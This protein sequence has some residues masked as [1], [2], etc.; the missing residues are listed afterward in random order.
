M[1]Y[2]QKGRPLA[3]LSVCIGRMILPFF[4]LRL[5]IEGLIRKNNAILTAYPKWLRCSRLDGNFQLAIRR[6]LR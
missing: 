3:A 4:Y 1:L 6:L 2:K 5:Q